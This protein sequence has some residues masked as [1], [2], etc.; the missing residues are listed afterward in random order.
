[1]RFWLASSDCPVATMY[2]GRDYMHNGQSVKA[3][4]L[5]LVS[6]H[7]GNWNS[8]FYAAEI[9]WGACS[10]FADAALWC[11]RAMPE[12]GGAR[13]LLKT[14]LEHY[15]SDIVPLGRWEPTRVHW[16]LLTKTLRQ[17]II[18]W[19][20]VARRLGVVRD[21]ALLICGFIVTL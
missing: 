10:N 15:E 8:M 3:L 16:R 7:A 5:F 6:A 13:S 20:M 19:L 18:Q 1:M 14:L 11:A 4:E 12:H 17:Q 2:L 9:L 21:I